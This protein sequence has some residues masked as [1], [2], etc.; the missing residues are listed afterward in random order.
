VFRW[1]KFYHHARRTLDPTLPRFRNLD[2]VGRALGVGREVLDRHV[3]AGELA[4]RRGRWGA[5]ARPVTLADE[6]SMEGLAR[7]RASRLNFVEAE[8]ALGVGRVALTELVKGGILPCAR[9]GATAASPWL[10]ERGAVDD[11]LAEMIG[12]LPVRAQGDRAATRTATPDLT[13]TDALA[14]LRAAGVGLPEVLRLAQSGDVAAYRL[15]DSVRLLDLRFDAASVG[16]FL[17]GRAPGEG[18]ARYTS[19]EV[20]RLLRCTQVTLRLWA[21]AGLLAPLGA[22]GPARPAGKRRGPRPTT[23]AMS[24]ASKRGTRGR[25]R[26]RR[27]S[28][29]ILKHCTHGYTQA[30][31]TTRSSGAAARATCSCSIGSA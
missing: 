1:L 17:A 8:A 14:S 19:T 11:A 16:A 10:F 2:Q 13:L 4:V 15:R 6:E 3:A 20:C 31:S 28:G 23:A 12:H 27:S 24:T 30:S 7:L 29:A 5:T 9:R 26:P 21:E 18:E 22:P 25:R